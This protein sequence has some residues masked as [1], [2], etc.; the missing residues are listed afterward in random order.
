MASLTDTSAALRLDPRILFQG[1]TEKVRVV[2]L[3]DPP[4]RV[5]VSGS[6][7]TNICIH[8]GAPVLMT[9]R[10]GDVSHTGTAIHGD[11]DIIP[12]GL[13]AS[14]E[15]QQRDMALVVSLTPGLVTMAVE[16][17]EADPNRVEI[18]NIFKARD[19][20]IEHIAWA[21]KNEM[22]S[23]YPGGSLYLDSLATAMAAQIVSRHSS[24]PVPAESRA[25]LSSRK[26]KQLLSYIEENLA[27]DL[28]LIAIAEVAGLSVSHCKVLFRRAMGV[29]IHQYVIRRRVERAAALLR[30]GNMAV[31]EVALATGFAHQSHLAAHI[32]RML[33]VTPR[34]LQR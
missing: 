23:G 28:S 5:E 9:C 16:E 33:G 12:P 20:G 4:G 34:D 6:E 17:L 24:L 21:L 8:V 3:T 22:E 11:I 27:S 31:S 26:L 14:W 13:P 10:H 7:R 25:G 18:R 30:E 15:I 19:A 2:L 29:P 1:S 32:R